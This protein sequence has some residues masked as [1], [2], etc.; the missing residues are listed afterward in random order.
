MRARPRKDKNHAAIVS[1][2]RGVGATV[3]DTS[4]M[5][6]GIPDLLAGYKGANVWIEVK[7]GA[8]SLTEDQLEFIARW[9]GGQVRVCRTVDEALR[10]IGAIPDKGPRF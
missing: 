6:G 3:A 5:G 9:R 7:D 10:A 1:A 2:L 4:A 8:G